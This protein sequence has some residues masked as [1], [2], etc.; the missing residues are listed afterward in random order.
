MELRRVGTL[1]RASACLV[2]ARTVDKVF[3]IYDVLA[4]RQ[5]IEV[6]V[7][8]VVARCTVRAI[9]IAAQ[10]LHGFQTGGTFVNHLHEVVVAVCL[11]GDAD[12]DTVAY[13]TA[14]TQDIP[15]PY[16]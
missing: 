10:L 15:R 11:D 16:W 3:R 13:L 9:V 2:D 14:L 7:R 8:R 5:N 12:G 1:H 6:I 4:L